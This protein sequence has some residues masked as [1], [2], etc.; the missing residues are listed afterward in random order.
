MADLSRYN[1]SMD[2]NYNGD[3]VDYDEAIDIITELESEIEKLKN[4][5]VVLELEIEKLEDQ[6]D[7]LKSDIGELEDQLKEATTTNN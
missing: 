6:V 7:N 3:W 5:I 1:P 2:V 4:N